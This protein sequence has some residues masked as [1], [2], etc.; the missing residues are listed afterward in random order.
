MTKCL[1]SNSIRIPSFWQKLVPL[2]YQAN[3][4]L[5]PQTSTRWKKI[6]GGLERDHEG[7]AG[8]ADMGSY[9]GKDYYDVF[10][11]S[12]RSALEAQEAQN[13]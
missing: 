5:C 2:P 4:L 10:M 12:Y 8:W 11:D 13:A 7:E 3:I 1:P 6:P 9:V